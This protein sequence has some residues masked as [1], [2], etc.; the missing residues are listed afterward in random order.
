[1]DKFSELV[2]NEVAKIIESLDNF[3]LWELWVDKLHL[4]QLFNDGDSECLLDEGHGDLL[5]TL[6]TLEEHL[7]AALIISDDALHHSN[8]LWKWAVVVI[9]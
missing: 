3:S 1:M 7:L 2:V 8:C 5:L 9:V 4:S 6:L